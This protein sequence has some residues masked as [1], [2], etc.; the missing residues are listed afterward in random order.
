MSA[1]ATNRFAATAKGSHLKVRLGR[2][3]TILPM[4]GRKEIG[5]GLENKIKQNLGLK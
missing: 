2:R 4:H 5:K 3:S 1:C